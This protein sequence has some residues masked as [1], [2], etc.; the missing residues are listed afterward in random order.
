MH[1]LITLCTATLLVTSACGPTRSGTLGDAPTGSPAG[2][3]S[4]VAAPPS[5]TAPGPPTA[6]AVPPG[7]RPVAGAPVAP[8]GPV[9]SGVASLDPVSGALAPATITIQVWFARAGKV[10]PTSRT[11]PYT[12]A[13]SR[14]ALTELAAG[15][16]TAETAAGVVS[17]VPAGTPFEIKGIAGGVA[18]VSFPPAFFAG[19][20][21]AAR[22][23]QAQV[24]FTLTQF[25]TV[26]RVGFQSAGEPAGWPVGRADYA[27]LLPAIVVFA[28]II[29]QRVSSPVRVTG[30]AQVFEA[31][32][33][34]RL[35]DAG[36]NEIATRFTTATC[37]TGCRGSYATDLPYRLGREQRGT[38]QVYEVSA[39]DGTPLNVVSIPVTLTATT[40]R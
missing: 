22:L 19:G 11:R 7:E 24:V 5:T 3:A 12:V 20:R 2:S 28:P 39:R 25:P 32:V 16:T 33:S 8:G 15:P 23:R 36:G 17:G 13:T 21:G 38:L 34:L 40:G 10:L 26:S 6:A 4:S 31:T 29:G 37:G 27:D 9:A 18:T 30:T 1:P 35:L 14:L